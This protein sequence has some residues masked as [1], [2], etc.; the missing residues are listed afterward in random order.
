MTRRRDTDVAI[1]CS[2]LSIAHAVARTTT[3]P[4]VV[5]GLTFT[6]AAGRTLAVFGPTGAGK[7]SLAAV[8]AGAAGHQFAVVGGEAIVAGIPVQRG[9]RARRTLTY[10]VGYLPQGEG[11]K[12]PARLTVAEVIGSPITSR[13]RRTNARAL[14]VRTATLLDELALPLGVAAKYP[15]ELSA[16]MRQR[17]ALAR[18]LVLQP[19]VLIADEP[20]ANLDVEARDATRRAI[21]RRRD[22]YGMATLMVTDDRSAIRE[23][24]AEVLIMRSGHAVAYGHGTDDLLWTPSSEADRRLVAS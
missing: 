17:V 22:G 24:D 3:A 4:R 2:D 12:L 1:R 9:G 7:S 14:A 16:G 20:F 6:V 23:L 21:L 10:L 5:D 11:A 15:Y 19:Q 8:L 13:D 18:A